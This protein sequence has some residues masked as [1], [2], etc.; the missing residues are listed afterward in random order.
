MNIT[1]KARQVLKETDRCQ[2]Q[3]HFTCSGK[4]HIF[5]NRFFFPPTQDSQLL[6]WLLLGNTQKICNSAPSFNLLPFVTADIKNYPLPH[7]A[8]QATVVWV[9]N[10]QL[11][12]YDLCEGTAT[13][14]FVTFS[15]QFLPHNA[16]YKHYI[17]N[18]ITFN[19]I[20]T[21][22]LPAGSRYFSLL[23]TAW[24][25]FGTHPTSTLMP[26]RVSFPGVKLPGYKADNSPPTSTKVRNEWSCILT[27]RITPS[28]HVWEL[29]RFA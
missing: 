5:L 15:A 29:Y 18:V 27:P 1:Y 22:Q 28:W 10:N 20:S 21:T 16:K 3:V 13:I 17:I 23:Q 19:H 4:S 8:K 12:Q 25:R 2:N 24:T 11:G 7:K 26:T 14:T 9:W 6:C